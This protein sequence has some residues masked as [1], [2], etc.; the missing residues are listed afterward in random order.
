MAV[1]LLIDPEN[2]ITKVNGRNLANNL[3]PIINNTGTEVFDVR[4][5]TPDILGVDVSTRA[6]SRG[7]QLADLGIQADESI[8]VRADYKQ[9]LGIVS[10]SLL[11]DSEI[12]AM[13]NPSNFIGTLREAIVRPETIA[14]WEIKVGWGG[15]RVV[16]PRIISYFVPLL[17]MDQRFS[18]SGLHPDIRPSI[19]I[20][21]GVE[22]AIFCNHD[23]NPEA[24][25]ALRQTRKTNE[26]L[27]RSFVDTFAPDTRVSFENDPVWDDDH[28]QLIDQIVDVLGQRAKYD[29]RLKQTLYGLADSAAAHRDPDQG[30]HMRQVM[31]YVAAHPQMFGDIDVE[32][33]HDPNKRIFNVINVK[34]TEFGYARRVIQEAI[35]EEYR[36]PR[37]SDLMLRTISRQIPP[38]YLTAGVD[39]AMGNWGQY[40]SAD[41]PLDGKDLNDIGKIQLEG[42][43]ADWNAIGA[44]IDPSNPVQGRKVYR[45]FLNWFEQEGQYRY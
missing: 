27:I 43:L 34:E 2:T 1:Q 6:V 25:A 42:A 39:V 23:N 14:N 32:G 15:S 16:S 35:G 40:A 30:N 4:S 8:P 45:E 29:R 9:I 17:N 3:L 18:G 5:L 41:V 12:R 31:R 20:F 19:T 33:R 7:L 11:G 37:V 26:K 38:Y 22:A 44:F 13:D 21:N 24:A 28:L 10:K 36:G